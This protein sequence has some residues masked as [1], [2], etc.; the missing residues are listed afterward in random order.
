ML[1]DAGLKHACEQ[2]REQGYAVVPDAWQPEE[3]RQGILALER[4]VETIR[5]DAAAWEDHVLWQRD[6]LSKQLAAIPEGQRALADGQIYIISDVA[7]HDPTL[8]AMVLDRCCAS[9]ASALLGGSAVCHFSN[10]TIRAATAGCACQWHRDWPNQYCTTKTGRQLRIMI[11][12]DGMQDGQGVTRVI[13]GSQ[14]WG[15]RQW[16]AWRQSPH[17]LHDEGVPLL[18][19]PGSLVVLGPTVVHGAGANLS[20]HPRRNLIAQWGAETDMICAQ[21]FEHVMGLSG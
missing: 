14:H 8:E 16:Q 20:S 10:A 5:Q 9:L 11:C 13:P 15:D 3:T 1:S 12:L 2:F 19:T 18:C 6:V 21:R 17:S 7:A 4:L